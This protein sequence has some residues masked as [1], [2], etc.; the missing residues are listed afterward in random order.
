LPTAS[1]VVPPPEVSDAAVERRMP[2][3]VTSTTTLRLAA[4]AAFTLGVSPVSI[5]V[6]DDPPL[7]VNR[8]APEVST[9]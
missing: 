6:H 9:E 7:A 3:L 8:R 5:G 1:N 4:W 2:R